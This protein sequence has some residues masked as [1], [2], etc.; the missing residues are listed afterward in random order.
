MGN[1]IIR[2]ASPEDAELLIAFMKQVGGESDNLT[3]GPDGLPISF[4]QE[5]AFLQM[6]KSEKRSVFLCA[7]KDGKLVGTGSLS[8]LPR[9]MNHRAELSVSVVRREWGHGIG[10]MMMDALITYAREHGIEILNP[11][12]RSDNM[13]AVRLYEKC[14][15]KRIGT[16]P[17]FFKIGDKYADFEL[18]YLDLR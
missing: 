8:A 1:L 13:R 16:S 2:E 5:R 7:W 11:E 17:A 10:S 15:F 4:E 6:M 18:M 9:R 12:V 14:G 3:Y